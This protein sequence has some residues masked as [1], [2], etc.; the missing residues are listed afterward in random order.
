MK[1]E[2]CYGIL[3]RELYNKALTGLMHSAEVNDTIIS[4]SKEIAR[5]GLI[6][7]YN[8]SSKNDNQTKLYNRVMEEINNIV[9]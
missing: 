1:I 9:I 7:I 5:T 8:N 3:A 2:T 6:A 4:I